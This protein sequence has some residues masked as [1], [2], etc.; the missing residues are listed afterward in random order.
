MV[1]C[2]QDAVRGTAPG[3][4]GWRADGGLV[5]SRIWSC[6][7]P[8]YGVPGSELLLQQESR[9]QGLSRA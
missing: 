7:V 8:E 9:V 2:I 3:R 1:Q 6:T 4:L 5:A